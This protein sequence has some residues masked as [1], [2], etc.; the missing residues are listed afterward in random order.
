MNKLLRFTMV[1]VLAIVANLSFA[2]TTVTFVAGT[3]KGSRSDSNNPGDDEVSKDGITVSVTGSVLGRTDQYRIFKGNTITVSSTVGNITKVVFTCSANGNAKYGPGNFTDATSG[4]YT[5]EENGKT[6]TWTGDAESFTMTASTNQVRATSIEVTYTSSS[7]GG[8]TPETLDAPVI[9]GDTPFLGSTTVTITAA[10]GTEIYYTTDGQTPDDRAGLLYTAP[11]TLTESVT[12]K[13]IAYKDA[14]ESPVASKDFN[15]QAPLT[16][17][18]TLANPYTA[19]DAINLASSLDK[20]ALTD[21][22]YV[23]GII[24][25]VKE[26]SVDYGNATYYIS[27]NGE[28]TNQFYIFR[29]KN[30]GK[31]NFTDASEISVGDE[32][33]VYG[34]LTNYY[35]NTPEMVSGNYIVSTTHK[36]TPVEPTYTTAEDFA[37][38]KTLESGVNAELTMTNAQV[39]YSWTS[40]NG[41]SSVYMRDASGALLVYNSGIELANNQIVNGTVILG[42]SEY[43]GTIQATKTELTNAEALTISEGEQAEAKVITMAEAIDNLSD[44]VELQDVN[45]VSETADD[46][47]TYY[48][49]KEGSR[50]QLYNGFHIDGL[51]ELTTG[52]GQKVRGIVTLFNNNAQITITELPVVTAISN[53]TANDTKNAVRYN[54][55]GQRV[56]ENYKGIVIE[57]GKKVVRK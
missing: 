36:D 40:L 37:A 2:Q 30:L 28:T 46:K 57:N 20:D 39:L 29:G 12:V 38:F 54:L 41:N 15:K 10:E 7:Q 56:G 6:G 44:Y 31:K 48:A 52:E 27:D 19:T 4:D 43:K 1:A 55:A 35:G 53:V 21:S 34:V 49:E 22:V 25:E 14:L 47:T 3:D 5:F 18:G 24:S 51:D 9:S 16:G 33:V 45:I 23:K 11:F 42:R 13:A 8:E 32:V 26:V 17:E 50:I